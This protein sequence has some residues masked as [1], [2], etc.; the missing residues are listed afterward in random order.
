MKKQLL[1]LLFAFF[2]CTLIAVSQSLD[3]TAIS[4]GGL[5]GDILNATI[6][7]V[8]VFSLNNS[9]LSLNSGSQ[10]DR[11]FTGGLTAVIKRNGED[12]GSDFLLIYPNP[13]ENFL[14]LQ[15]N[16]L[17]NETITFQIFDA[18]A[19][20]LM[21]Q[22]NVSTD[23]IF[24]LKVSQLPHGHYYIRASTSLG[25]WVEKINFIKL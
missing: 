9:G 25:G 20:L 24:Q 1:V 11:N 14:N 21:Q 10:S 15:I 17:L 4:S 2:Y 3:R 7:E 13:V 18:D 19:K 23:H 5:S 6:G 22:K 8:F 12:T 16:G